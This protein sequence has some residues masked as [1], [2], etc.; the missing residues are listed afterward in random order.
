MLCECFVA[1]ALVNTHNKC[2]LKLLLE[3]VHEY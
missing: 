3:I 1:A 2:L